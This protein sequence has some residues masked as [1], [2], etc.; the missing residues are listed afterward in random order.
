MTD[1]VQFV[2]LEDLLFEKE[3]KRCQSVLTDAI[4][5]LLAEG[6]D[7]DT[8]GAALTVVYNEFLGTDLPCPF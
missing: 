8:I 1:I 7:E 2:P 3:A 6:I 4:T 5:Q